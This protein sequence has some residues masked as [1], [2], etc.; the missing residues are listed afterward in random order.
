MENSMRDTSFRIY[1]KPWYS[2]YT[3]DF[4]RESNI[5]RS[6]VQTYF[7]YFLSPKCYDG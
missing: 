1:G 5:Y 7:E 6:T 4:F 3:G 2:G